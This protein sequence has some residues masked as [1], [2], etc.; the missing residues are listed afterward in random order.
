MVVR[1]FR[2][3]PPRLRVT[4]GCEILTRRHYDRSS[5][6]SPDECTKEFLFISKGL[7]YSYKSLTRSTTLKEHSTPTTTAMCGILNHSSDDDDD[8]DAVILQ[9]I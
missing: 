8:A 7:D 3:L 2:V 9:H 4:Y 6:C 5:S 1:K